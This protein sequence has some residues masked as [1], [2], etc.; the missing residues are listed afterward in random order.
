MIEEL[1][2]H[3]EVKFADNGGFVSPSGLSYIG[4]PGIRVLQVYSPCQWS[5]RFVTLHVVVAEGGLLAGPSLILSCSKSLKSPLC[6]GIRP[7]GNGG[8][9]D[10]LHKLARPSVDSGHGTDVHCSCG[11]IKRSCV[12]VV[13]QCVRPPL[14]VQATRST[15]WAPPP[16][17]L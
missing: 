4:E 5:R 3:D 10:L 1:K 6:A 15:S 11:I 9:L 7:D 2:R 8:M 14:N 12:G 17:A 13:A 16:P